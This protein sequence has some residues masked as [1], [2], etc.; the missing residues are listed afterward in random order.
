[1]PLKGSVQRDRGAAAADVHSIRPEAAGW[2]VSGTTCKL[3]TWKTRGSRV[4]LCCP[5]DV[6]RLVP[7]VSVEQCVSRELPVRAVV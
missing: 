5:I 7:W 3:G 1:M 4:D 2:Q 6:D